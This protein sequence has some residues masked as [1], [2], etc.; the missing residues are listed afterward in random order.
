LLVSSCC[1]T[2][3][4][5]V[6]H[7]CTHEHV[8]THT[9]QK[10][11]RCWGYKI[12]IVCRFLFLFVL[13]EIVCVC[14]CVCVCVHIHVHQHQVFF[15]SLSTVCFESGSLTESRVHRFSHTGWLASPEYLPNSVPSTLASTRVPEMLT[16][17][18][19]LAHQASYRL[20]HL[21]R[22]PF[23]YFKTHFSCALII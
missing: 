8:H 21:P 15:Q 17:V 20:S 12:Q 16:Q 10:S 18:P 3:T 7:T 4:Q 19:V 14:V 11:G 2:C 5:V 22:P 6:H 9:H 23:S 1:P 13:G